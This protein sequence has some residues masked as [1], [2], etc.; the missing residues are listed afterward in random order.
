MRILME[1]QNQKSKSNWV[2]PRRKSK[3]MKMGLGGTLGNDKK[4]FNSVCKLLKLLFKLL[5]IV[6]LQDA[7]G[8]WPTD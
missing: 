3:I 4:C 7:A 5:N 1:Y 2:W 8:I 6:Y